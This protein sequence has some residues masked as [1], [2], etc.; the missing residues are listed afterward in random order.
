[1][2]KENGLNDDTDDASR[3]DLI[4]TNWVG[5]TMNEKAKQDLVEKLKGM[6]TSEFIEYIDKGLDESRAILRLIRDIQ[7][8]IR[9]E[10][11]HRLNW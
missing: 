7:A 3:I 9:F 8:Q 1:M 5:D 11:W 10:R 4:L 2:V 6:S